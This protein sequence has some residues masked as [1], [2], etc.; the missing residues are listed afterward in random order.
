MML[1]VR[2][3]LKN[4]HP[5]DNGAAIC[6]EVWFD[7]LRLSDFNEHGGWAANVRVT[8]KL[9]DLGTVTLAGN[10]STSGFGSIE[11][12]MND[13][14]LTT[15]T[16]YDF[17]SNVELGKFLPKKSGIHVP[18]FF[19]YSETWI[20]PEY[21]PLDPDILYTS[22]LSTAATSEQKSNLETIGV[23]YTRR[24]SINFTNVKKTKTGGGKS[25]IYDV[26]NFSLNY[27]YTEMDHHDVSTDYDIETERK[28]GIAY[29]FTATPKNVTPF[30]KSKL[31]GKNKYLKAIK[32]FNFYY[33]PSSIAIK[34][35][36]DRT[37]VETH[38]RDNSGLNIPLDTTFSK[39]FRFNRAYSLKFDLT[40]SLKFDFNTNAQATVDEPQGRIDTREK[41][42]TII[43]NLLSLGRL[44]TYHQTG[45]LNYTVPLS[46]FPVLDW[47]SLT[48]RYSA[49]YGWLAGPLV[50]DSLSGR[51][52]QGPNHNTINNAQTKALNG[53][54]NMV[55]LYNKFPYLKKLN[56]PPKQ[57]PKPLKPPKPPPKP[58][59]AADSVKYK[60]YLDSLK[61]N[62]PPSV[63]TRAAW[64]ITKLAMMVKSVGFTYT[65]TNA[66]SFAGFT[67]GSTAINSG[68]TFLGNGWSSG[69]PA[70]GLDFVAGSQNEALFKQRFFENGWLGNQLS[71]TALNAPFSRTQLRNFLGRASIEPIKNF[72]IELTANR[73]YSLNHTEYFKYNPA[74][75]TDTSYSPVESGTF[76]MSYLTW[77]TA[78]VKD[79]GDY[80][81]KTFIQFANNRTIISSR[82][83]KQNGASAGRID[84]TGYYDGYSGTQQDVLTYAFLAA[85]SGKSAGNIA[86]NQFP[87][88]PLPNWRITYDG[89]GKLPALQKIFTSV[90]L[91][92]GYRS[93]YTVKFILPEPFV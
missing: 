61:R 7:E 8:S 47:I 63:L 28:G 10:H 86:M 48:A 36:P 83:A 40:K 15:T 51:I 31:F 81:N 43:N 58:K 70:P 6:A 42:D 59:T 39:S 87:S 44:T 38:L 71:D 26:E 82:L 66:M 93:S 27:V 57:P 45:N 74:T 30:A 33:S 78:F 49:D 9:A 19:G 13:R 69:I 91:S 4:S 5:N 64:D 20:T 21:D 85:Y 76:S 72:K 35:D 80:S 88:I 29:N 52:V 60:A 23:D 55:T 46:K 16:G 75:G 18:F 41:R 22:A 24:K 89:L 77:N 25:H 2:N 90:S 32:D 50:L 3:P 68:P 34:W 84:T 56:S 12:K 11:Q 67:G 37:Y 1:G 62:A 17:S 54:F 73:N 65:E 79:N 92:H 14:S 53:Q